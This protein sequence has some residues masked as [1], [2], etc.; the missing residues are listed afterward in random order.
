MSLMPV[1]LRQQSQHCLERW[2]YLPVWLCKIH[3][4]HSL[5]WGGEWLLLHHIPPLELRVP[6]KLQGW[7]GEWTS[8][9]KVKVHCGLWLQSQ[10]SGLLSFIKTY[11]HFLL[12]SKFDEVRIGR[13]LVYS[14]AINQMGHPSSQLRVHASKEVIDQK[15]SHSSRYLLKLLEIEV[16]LYQLLYPVSL[17]TT[18]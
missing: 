5:C 11:L 4:C 9:V 15:S 2:L 13:P 10:V 7:W 1:L 17:H 6:S 12:Y 14:L 3:H 8:T 16:E 18:L